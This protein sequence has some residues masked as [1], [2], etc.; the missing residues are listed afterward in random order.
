[1]SGAAFL[2]GCGSVH[3]FRDFKSKRE[4]ANRVAD[5]AKNCDYAVMELVH[6]MPGQGVCSMFSFGR[7]SGVADGALALTVPERRIEEVSP[8]K[9]QNFYRNLF[10]VSR[11]QQ[12]D[13]VQIASRLD[14]LFLPYL[15]RKK[16]HNSADAILIASWKILS[17]T[18]LE[19]LASL[20]GIAPRH[21]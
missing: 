3:G 1:M 15:T 18:N 14:P 21:D 5:L 13:A 10:G 6:A 20:H 9:W 8:Q 11:K 17:G 12:F 7:S 19:P 16:D 2:I 4:L